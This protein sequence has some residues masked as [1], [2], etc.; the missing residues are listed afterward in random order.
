MKH[1]HNFCRIISLIVLIAGTFIIANGQPTDEPRSLQPNETIE[2]EMTGKE[3]HRYKFDLKTGEFFQVHVEQKGLDVS[4]KLLDEKGNV[5]ATMDSP[6]GKEGFETLTFVA[7]KDGSFILETISPNEKAEKG[8]YIIKREPSR[9]ANEEDRK[10]VRIESDF[11]EG[12]QVLLEVANRFQMAQS[13]LNEAFK[14]STNSKENSLLAKS[15][16]DGLVAEFRDISAKGED[17]TTTD[18][19]ALF[20]GKESEQV[21][22]YLKQLSLQSKFSESVSFDALANIHSNFGEWKQ[23]L[24]SQK[25]SV[26]ISQ[27]VLNENND[28]EKYGFPKQL[29]IDIKYNIGQ[30]LDNIAGT[31][32]ARL[33]QI[34]ESIK[35]R[36]Q[37]LEIYQKL[38]EETQ[39]Q[40]Y[41]YDE[42]L[43][44]LSIGLSYDRFSKDK[45]LA[46]EYYFKSLEIYRVIP[47]ANTNSAEVLSLIASGYFGRLN[48]EL[49]ERYWNEAFI[50][51]QENND[52]QGQAGVLRSLATMFWSI[53]NKE[54]FKEFINKNLKILLSSDYEENWKLTIRSRKENGSNVLSE[55]ALDEFWENII[56]RSRFNSI[57]FS[58]E[59]LEDYPLSLEY[60][61]KS[62]SVARKSNEW[63][64]IVRYTADIAFTYAKME[65]WEEATEFY[66]QSLELSKTYGTKEE[67]AIS[68]ADVGWTLLE[69]GKFA[70]ALEY[71]NKA[72]EL[73]QSIGVDE[74][75]AYSPYYNSLLAQISRTY[76][77]LGNKRLAIMYGK[78]AVNSIQNERQRLQ[79][80]DPISQK[81]F[82]EKR[83]KHYRR[84][85]E[86]LVEAGRLVEAEQVLAMLKQEEVA[87][88]LRADRTF[89]AK[90]NLRIDYTA[91]EKE[92]LAEYE[93]KSETL[94][95]I[96][97]EFSKLEELKRKGVKLNDE[98]EKQFA[99][100]NE[101]LT[102]ANQEFQNFLDELGKEFGKGKD[103]GIGKGTGL[104]IQGRL[105][106]WGN[107]MS[108]IY[109]IVGDNLNVVLHTSDV[110]VSKESTGKITS[111][112][113]N[114][115]IFAFRE[116]V[117]NP[118]V[119]PRPLGKELYDVLIKPF[120]AE[121]D[122][123]KTK[124]ILWSLDA[125]LRLLPL[126]ALWDGKQYLG[127]KYQNVVITQAGLP[128]IGDEVSSNPN[129]LAL[130]VSESKTVEE[131]LIERKF[132]FNALPSVPLELDS[133]VKT[134]KSKKGVLIGE[135]L[136]NQQFT[137]K[138]FAEQ[139]LKGYKIVHIASHFSMNAGDAS[140]S[141]LLLGDGTT[142]TVNDLN[143]DPTIKQKF[144]GVELLVLSAC[145][146]AVGYI[147][148]GEDD[149]EGSNG[150]EVEGFAYVAQQNGAKSIIATL[151]SVADESTALLMS[152]FYRIKK[153]NPNLTKAEA[154]QMAQKQMIEGK[155]KVDKKVKK[156][157]RAE[158]F[159]SEG[160]DKNLPPFEFDE[161]KPFA[162]P[163]YWSPFV[164]IGNWK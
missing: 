134:K 101:N 127:Q 141:F 111:A 122:A 119:D 98:Q 18:K 46:I 115:K 109:T 54:K 157:K 147:E 148:R 124:T 144:Q 110:N 82:L 17:K 30:G 161:S 151:W 131:T 117:K 52:K 108:Y 78:R 44:I 42:A 100:L 1:K 59:L 83:E 84:L 5:L 153:A 26:N 22:L 75:R 146:T 36:K 112:E 103:E 80:L 113:L 123:S 106:G 33:G 62:L 47:N 56:K 35:Y 164:L 27:K 43:A 142:L 50:I 20:G 45:P 96:G 94:S 88:Y 63:R 160:D 114:K 28:L 7:D 139:L 149:D 10:R 150:K 58:Y 143:I 15:T 68:T 8:N 126:A 48:Y 107:G 129:V 55:E 132:T 155:L 2:R 9:T 120:E 31:L 91:K 13:K 128:D 85:A 163:Y 89:A 145:D 60:Y 3:T 87:D 95:A 76:Y 137:R 74:N 162:H 135:S 121:L 92:A 57:G 158:V 32:D 86:W 61:Q 81:G 16:I 12:L 138:S 133:I 118:N 34:E 14:Q 154:M 152:E 116:A 40:R 66:K 23:Y 6:N 136:L 4:L 73:F 41:K 70:E 97:L 105:K 38:F 156:K 77:A 159:G 93:E 21:L 67:V 125:N 24:E 53:G 140:R 102:K 79:N 69:S 37:A 65:K 90:L 51:Y 64:D 19:I 99:E 39:N 11:F 72:L 130:G 49:A 104:N 29:L 71:Q 25:L